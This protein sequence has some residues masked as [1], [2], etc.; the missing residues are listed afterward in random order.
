MQDVFVAELGAERPVCVY[1]DERLKIGTF[2][3]SGRNKAVVVF[4][5]S[6]TARVLEGVCDSQ[7][8]YSADTDQLV[9]LQPIGQSS[10]NIVIYR[11]VGHRIR[12][13]ISATGATRYVFD[14]SAP[15]YEMK[16]DAGT[17]TLTPSFGVSS[18]GRWVAVELR[19]RGIATIDAG[20]F[21][22]KQ[23]TAVGIAYGYGLDPSEQLAISNDGKSVALTGQNAGFRLFDVTT[24]CGQQ[25]VG[26]LTLIATTEQC[27]ST[28]LG[29]VTLFPNFAFAERPRFFGNGHQLEVIVT[30]WV[31]G[32]RRV[33]FVTQGT[34]IAHQLKLLSLG[35]SFSSGE[36][37]TDD[38]YYL[39]GT[40]QQYDRC[41]VSVRSY[42]PLTAKRLGLHD[43][44]AKN[45][46]CSGARISDVVGSGD[47]YW[48]QGDRLGVSGLGVSLVEKNQLQQ[49]AVETYRPGRALQSAFV[50]RYDPEMLTI[51]IGGNDAGLMGKLR[52]CAMP[53]TCEWVKSPGL[54]ET[55]GEIKRLYDTLGSLFLEISSKAPNAEVYVLGYPDIVEPDGVCDPVTAFLLDR[56][57]RIFVQNSV[58]YLNQVIRAAVNKAGFHYVDSEHSFDGTKLCSAAPTSMNGVRIGDDFAVTGVL[59]MLKIIGTETFHP[60]PSGHALMT[61]TI[62]NQYPEL[63][64]SPS[65]SDDEGIEP[66]HYWGEDGSPATR[67]AYAT[68]FAYKDGTNKQHMM[69]RLPGGSLQPHSLVSV[70][71]HS[72]PTVLATFVADEQGSLKGDISVPELL[73]EGFHTLHLLGVNKGGEAI[74]MYQFLTIG[75]TDDVIQTSNGEVSKPSSTSSTMLIDEIRSSPERN[76]HSAV[77]TADVLGVQSTKGTV[78][79]IKKL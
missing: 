26:T 19:G 54:E 8:F 21:V 36:G 33:T 20:S 56:T 1:G 55:A 49:E 73:G 79:G 23:I 72:E 30:S 2:R 3:G 58:R 34:V 16:N 63:K 57:E 68:E 31:T 22:S 29:V 12:P 50:E 4:P 74:D 69:V 70:E 7:C 64:G 46:S 67:A 60:T 17:Y 51:G 45:I 38:A 27:P 71:V 18:N 24:D 11:H 25:L 35:D 10:M 32:S 75:A 41:H 65:S 62:L 48:G 61:E 43:D 59:P 77:I 53:G 78:S 6:G 39:T 28:D 9:T 47:G 13:E 52:T 37:E 5:Y 40:N 66:S 42:S 76:R 44:E 14:T 15:D